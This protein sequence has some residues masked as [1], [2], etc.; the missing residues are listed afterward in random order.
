[1]TE[2][3]T[4]GGGAPASAGGGAAASAGGAV[5]PAGV[6]APAG[7]SAQPLPHSL[8]AWGWD[9]P[10]AAAFAADTAALGS[11]CGFATHCFA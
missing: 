2:L 5:A 10:W 9:E 7:V 6:A 4:P 3:Q 8:A 11:D 1:M